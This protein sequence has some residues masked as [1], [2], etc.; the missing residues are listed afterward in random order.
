MLKKD[1][2]NFDIIVYTLVCVHVSE[3][4][5]EGGRGIPYICR[6]FVPFL[7]LPSA[8]SHILQI[9]NIDLLISDS[10]WQYP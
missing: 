4:E 5:I 7:V 9:C 3:S 10:E 1:N 6:V 8:Y 2:D